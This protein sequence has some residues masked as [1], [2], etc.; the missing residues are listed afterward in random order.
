MPGLAV[1]SRMN[2]PP[3]SAPRGASTVRV[4]EVA[5]HHTVGQRVR[6]PALLAS[7]TD[8]CCEYRS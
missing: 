1:T 7:R 4:K 2:V 8:A 6:G 3:V 5:L